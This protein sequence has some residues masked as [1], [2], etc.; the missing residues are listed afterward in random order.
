LVKDIK[1]RHGPIR[2][3]ALY[4][5]SDTICHF[6]VPMETLGLK[7]EVRLRDLINHKYY[8][9]VKGELSENVPARS[10]MIFKAEGEQRLEPTLYE[11]ECAYLP[12]YDDL[13]K[14]KKQILYAPINGASGGMGIIN[15]GGSIDNYAEW[16]D[17]YS[18]FGGHYYMTIKYVPK[19]GSRLIVN[20]NGENFIFDKIPDYGKISSITLPIVLNAGSNIIKMGSPYCW[21][22]DIDCFILRQKL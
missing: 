21:A 12:C 5:P 4:N 10:A 1:K 15:L 7:G 17:V 14:K 2:A 11:A 18:N 3:V 13:G 8:K 9:L 20:V 16:N 6:I 19:K 22:P